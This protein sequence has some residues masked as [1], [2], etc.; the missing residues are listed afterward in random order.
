[1]KS[2]KPQEIFSDPSFVR[3]RTSL[4]VKSALNK[5][6]PSDHATKFPSGE[7]LGSIT[8]PATFRFFKLEPDVW[9]TNSCPESANATFVPELSIE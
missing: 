8:G 7:S 1:M 6:F 4:P 3:L 2:A 9:P 5:S